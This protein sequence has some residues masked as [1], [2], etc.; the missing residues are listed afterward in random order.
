MLCRKDFTSLNM[1]PGVMLVLDF[2]ESVNAQYSNKNFTREDLW[3]TLAFKYNFFCG[4]SSK[5]KGLDSPKNVNF[6][7]IN[8]PAYHLCIHLFLP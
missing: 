4:I 1:K 6:I 2:N 8:L 3:I 5:I 7:F